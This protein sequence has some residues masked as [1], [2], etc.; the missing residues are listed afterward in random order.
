MPESEVDNG[1]QS[2]MDISHQEQETLILLRPG[3]NLKS[4]GIPEVGKHFAQHLCY[5]RP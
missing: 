4:S 1:S 2:R 5:A 3:V